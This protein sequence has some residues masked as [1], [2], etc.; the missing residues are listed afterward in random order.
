MRKAAKL[1]GLSLI[2]FVA[3]QVAAASSQAFIVQGHPL[4]VAE[5]AS[6]RGGE[7]WVEVDR[8]RSV[9]RVTTIPRDRYGMDYSRAGCYSVEVRNVVTTKLQKGSGDAYQPTTFP[10]TT[11]DMQ[12]RKI[13]DTYRQQRY[14]SSGGEWIATDAVATVTA[15]PV[16]AKGEADMSKP[17]ARA[18]SGYFWH[19]NNAT[20]FENSVSAGC[21]L[22][23]QKDIDRVISTLAADR[24][25]KKISVH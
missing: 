25:P 14:G 20:A 2:A 21:L 9:A 6:I 4:T 11:A 5:R 8:E 17:Y 15:Y 16:N 3:I 19:A 10:V 12:V 13:A 22:S 7:T 23:R 1:R 18:D 24:G